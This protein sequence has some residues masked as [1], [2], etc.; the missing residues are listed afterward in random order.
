MHSLIRIAVLMF[1]LGAGAGLFLQIQPLAQA[2]HHGTGAEVHHAWVRP[3]PPGTTITAMYGTIRNGG[4]TARRLVRVLC[5]KAE[6]VEIHQAVEK[7][8]MMQMRQVKGGLSIPAGGE[9]HFE[10]GG[11]HLMLIGLRSPVKPGEEVRAVFYFDNGEQVTVTA[12]VAQVGETPLGHAGRHGAGM[13]RGQGK[14]HDAG[15]HRKGHKMP[16][17]MP[18]RDFQGMNRDQ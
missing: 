15:G 11:Y 14:H 3:T 9:V 7:D 16:H 10:P 5:E 6:A 12:R 18:R 1:F 17:R 4:K 13:H 2:Q 8:G